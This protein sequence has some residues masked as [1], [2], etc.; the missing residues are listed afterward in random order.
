MVGIGLGP[1]VSTKQGNPKQNKKIL[2]H[3]PGL[4][5]LLAPKTHKGAAAAAA[6][7][8]CKTTA[9]MTEAEQLIADQADLEAF[10]R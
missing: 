9:Q 7:D 5:L 10:A 1:F 8:L 2:P 6:A 3:V 4:H